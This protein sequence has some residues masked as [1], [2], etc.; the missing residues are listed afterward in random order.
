MTLLIGPMLARQ[1]LRADLLNVDILKTYPLH[2]WQVV[3]GE[4]LTPLSILSG[5]IWLCLLV[6]FLLLPGDKVAWLTPALRGG[7]A[8]GLAI[9]AP[10]L[11]AIQLLVSNAATV[12]FP[13]WTQS[14]GSRAERGIEVM[15]QR[16]IFITGQLLITVIAMVPAVLSAALI[17]VIAQWL[18]GVVTAAVLAVGAVFLLLCAEACLGVRWLG[19][20]FEKFDL[21]AEL[22]V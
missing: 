3:A 12:I 1:D 2:G 20:R 8:L 5:V 14:A 11:V 10:P 18:V 9:L 21:S 13:A 16:I 19:G 6:G 15:G 7:A 4:L 17:F 22:R